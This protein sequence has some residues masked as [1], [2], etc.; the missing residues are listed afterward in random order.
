MLVR[1]IGVVAAVSV[2]VK[3][4]SN[5]TNLRRFAVYGNLQSCFCF[6]HL[7]HPRRSGPLYRE[8]VQV[9]IQKLQMQNEKLHQ[10]RKPK[11]HHDYA[12]PIPMVIYL[13]VISK[14][15]QKEI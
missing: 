3:L 6:Q 1:I 5:K 2:F 13:M 4:N 8:M 14:F 11:H 9:S 7:S 12:Y 10:Q 15:R